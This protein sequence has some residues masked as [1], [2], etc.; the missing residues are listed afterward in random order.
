MGWLR[1][2]IG[3]TA[4]EVIGST[5]EVI[6]RFVQTKEEKAEAK[7]RLREL[8][9]EFRKLA[10]EA[11]FKYL[12]DREGARRLYSTDSFA[13]KVYALS[14]LGGYFVITA[15]L[16]YW[17]LAQFTELAAVDVPSWAVSLISSIFGAMSTKVSTITDFFF[18]GSQG[19]RDR[20]HEITSSFRSAQRGAE[21]EKQEEAG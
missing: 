9:L 15:G 2:M 18:G 16:M 4:G 6:D 12:E 7:L 19:E 14:F 1:D 10:M 11:E 20:G 13:Q 17:L 3:N 21:S 5:G 8:E